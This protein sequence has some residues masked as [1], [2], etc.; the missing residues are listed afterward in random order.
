MLGWKMP[1]STNDDVNLLQQPPKVIMGY[2]RDDS[3][4]KS[5]D[6]EGNTP[7]KTHQQKGGASQMINYL[8]RGF[9]YF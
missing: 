7:L 8:G 3:P 4:R 1:L 9:K 5:F 2:K 6:F